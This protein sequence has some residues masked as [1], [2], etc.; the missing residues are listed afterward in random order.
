[1][2]ILRL[3]HFVAHGSGMETEVNIAGFHGYIL[4]LAPAGVAPVSVGPGPLTFPLY[5][6]APLWLDVS[7]CFSFSSRARVF[8]VAGMSWASSRKMKQAFRNR[9]AIA[10]EAKRKKP[11]GF[12]SLARS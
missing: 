8:R 11:W 12:G 5:V 3:I 9:V 7:F 10:Y 4:R 2:R 6:H 1:M